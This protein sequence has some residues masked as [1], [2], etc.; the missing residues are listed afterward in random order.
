SAFKERNLIEL[1]KDVTTQGYYLLKEGI[2]KKDITQSDNIDKTDVKRCCEYLNRLVE[3]GWKNKNIFPTVIKWGI[4]SPF[5]FSIKFNSDEWFPWLQLYGLGQTGK[6]TL[7]YIVL[8]I[9]NLNN[10]NNVLG[11][12]HIDS[13]AR[14]GNIASK[15]TYPK[16]INEVGALLT[17]AYGKYTP[18][19]E[20]IKHSVESITVRGKYVDNNSNSFA[21]Y[22]ETPALCPMI[23]TSNY[24]PLSDSGFNRRLVSIHFPKEEKKEESEQ[25]Q[26]KED[27][28][29]NKKYLRVLGDFVSKKVIENPKMLTEKFWKDLSIDL[30]VEFYKFADMEIP[31][32]IYNFEEQRDAIDESNELTHFGLRAFLINKV[33]ELYSRYFNID[34]SEKERSINLTPIS[35]KVQYCLRSSLISFLHQVDKDNMIITIDLMKELR[36]NNIEN[37]TSLKDIGTLLQFKYTFKNFGGKKMRVLEGRI[38][39]FVKFLDSK[40]T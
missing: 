40:I 11:F 31:K 26:F 7:G 15:D 24:Q 36:N 22:Q 6:T 34:S 17:N 33:N 12:N 19:I 14:F 13:V 8:N 20:L 10:K 32:W 30:L 35:H 28:E 1:K 38:D 18:I 27:F 9:W 25:Q 37:I 29:E 3:S 2:I 23:F 39:Y 5:S 16:L 21:S 4:L